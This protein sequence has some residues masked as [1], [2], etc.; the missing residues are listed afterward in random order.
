M[1]QKGASTLEW[2]QRC[3]KRDAVYYPA[4]NGPY[5]SSSLS[6]QWNIAVSSYPGP[7]LHRSCIGDSDRKGIQGCGSTWCRRL[8]R[9]W[10]VLNRDIAF[11]CCPSQANYS[12][13]C[14]TPTHFLHRIWRIQRKRVGS[15]RTL[16]SLAFEW[17]TNALHRKPVVDAISP[18]TREMWLDYESY[19]LPTH[20]DEED[21]CSG[22]RGLNL[23]SRR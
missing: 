1:V 20:T 3:G 10:R 23:Y 14:S 8:C 15:F 21:I 2:D 17:P 13:S 16:K 22:L 5:Y 7:K 9:D 18:R 11:S 6:S 19:N 12:R 4:L